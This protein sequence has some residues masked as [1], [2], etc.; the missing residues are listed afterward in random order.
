[1]EDNNFVVLKTSSSKPSH[2]EQSD[3][4]TRD[5]KN[6]DDEEM[7]LFIKRYQR[8]IRENKHS[9]KNL[10][11]F[12][13]LD[14]SSKEYEN[15]KDKFRSSCYNNG[16]FCHYRPKY[17]KIKKYKEKGHHKKSS[18]SGRAYVAWERVS[19][20]SSDESS[21]SS[22]ESALILLMANRKE[23]KNVS[24]CNLESIN[25]LSYLQL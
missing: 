4:E 22:V 21:T 8:Y 15:K 9:D 18:K 6:F 24:L 10:T 5:Y 7:E 20:S 23:K 13:R 12:R 19:D 11:K 2:I 14:K 25:E 1:M 17:P 16:E 3:C